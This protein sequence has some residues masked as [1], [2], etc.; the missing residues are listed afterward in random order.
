MKMIPTISIVGAG[1]IRPLKVLVIRL[2]SAGLQCR[3]HVATSHMISCYLKVL[4][5]I[6]EFDDHYC[7]GCLEEIGYRMS[8]HIVSEIFQTVYFNTALLDISGS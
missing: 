5:D 2:M 4:V 7:I 8:E 3:E 1:I 6:L